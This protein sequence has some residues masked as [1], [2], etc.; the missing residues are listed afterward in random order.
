MNFR[1]DRRDQWREAMRKGRE[2]T[3]DP[4]LRGIYSGKGCLIA[5]LFLA[6]L[7]AAVVTICTVR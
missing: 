6:I 5:V 4:Q 3:E 7:V 2:R 1:G